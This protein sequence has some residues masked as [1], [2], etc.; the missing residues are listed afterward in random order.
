MTLGDQ[1]RPSS[2]LSASNLSINP[3][4]RSLSETE[5]NIALGGY[6][7]LLAPI[8]NQSAAV[9]PPS[10][11]RA[12]ATG[13]GARLMDNTPEGYNGTQTQANDG[14]RAGGRDDERRQAG[15]FSTSATPTAAPLSA[16]QADTAGVETVIAVQK[17]S[18][19][20]EQSRLLSL[21]PAASATSTQAPSAAFYEWWNALEKEAEERLLHEARRKFSDWSVNV[22]LDEFR[23]WLNCASF[24]ADT[25][26]LRTMRRMLIL[27]WLL[28]V[29]RKRQHASSIQDHKILTVLDVCLY[30]PRD[31]TSFPNEVRENIESFM[32]DRHV[33]GPINAARARMVSESAVRPLRRCEEILHA[34]AVSSI[35]SRYVHPCVVQ[36][37]EGGLMQ[38]HTEIPTDDFAMRALF[39]SGVESHQEIGTL[40]SAHLAIDGFEVEH[41]FH[42]PDYGLWRCFWVERCNRLRLSLMW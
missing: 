20:L 11:G 12:L 31:S 13:L 26:M 27:T 15:S 4:L 7:R 18:Q 8:H 30:S 6:N 29:H 35:M 41:R 37:A 28:V 36:A 17:L 42:D 14:S 5:A 34:S 39:E 3:P 10:R 38:C 2:P 32:G 24:Q 23:H 25:R 33:W 16:S 1:R 22:S 40:L 9:E 21:G 19:R